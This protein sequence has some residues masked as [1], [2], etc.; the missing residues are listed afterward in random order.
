MAKRRYEIYYD[1]ALK[2]NHWLLGYFNGNVCRSM[3]IAFAYS[4]AHD[5]PLESIKT[6][7]IM[8]SRSYQ[9]FIIMYSETKQKKHRKAHSFDNVWQVLTS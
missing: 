3:E 6:E 1:K 8:K 7:L 9:Y 5:V 2:R 4:K